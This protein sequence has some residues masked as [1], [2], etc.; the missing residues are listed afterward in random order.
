MKNRRLQTNA[1]ILHASMAVA[2]F[3]VGA[4]SMPLS[5]TVGALLRRKELS[6]TIC[7]I[8]FANQ[9][10]L[11]A[12]ICSSLYHV[13]LVAWERYVAFTKWM[14]YNV[15]IPRRRV[16]TLAITAWLLAVFT[17]AP[18]RIL[19]VAGVPFNIYIRIFNI[20]SLLPA[21]VCMALIGYFYAKIYLGARKRVQIEVAQ[22]SS[23]VPRARHWRENP[24]AKRTLVIIIVSFF[25]YIPSVSFLLFVEAVQFLHTSSAFR[26][27]ELLVQLTSLV[28]PILYC[29]VLDRHFRNMVFRMMTISKSDADQSI[30]RAPLATIRRQHSR[31]NKKCEGRFLTLHEFFLEERQQFERINRPESQNCYSTMVDD[32]RHQGCTT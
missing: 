22:A 31:R 1:N 5:I 24:I 11:C 3:F 27:S 19:K 9:I 15:I 2:N 30:L 18:V 26:W 20:I 29:L 7:E 6:T 28:N 23:D 14:Q 25:Y 21:A 10:V 13:T 17:T 16:K 12:T 8:A 4:G 32:T